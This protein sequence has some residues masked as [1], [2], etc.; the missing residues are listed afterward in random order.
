M[1]EQTYLSSGFGYH[2]KMDEIVT[3]QHHGVN[4]SG[5]HL[6]N[7]HKLQTENDYLRERILAC[8]K[9]ITNIHQVRLFTHCRYN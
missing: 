4:M 7:N 3:R 6:D 2:N 8:E 5:V 1:M 9:G